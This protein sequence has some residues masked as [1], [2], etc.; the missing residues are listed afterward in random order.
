MGYSKVDPELKRTIKNLSFIYKEEPQPELLLRIPNSFPD[1]KY[2]VRH[3]TEEFTSVCP[4][5]ISQPDHAKIIIEFQPREFL[6]EL[7]SLKFF[8]TSFRDVEI[9]HEQVPPYIL[10]QLVKLLDPKWIFVT[11]EFTTRGGLRTTVQDRYVR[12]RDE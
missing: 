8:L 12:P 11:G 7:K 1:S 10:D 4:L 5:N 6:V 9:F 3:E 2:T